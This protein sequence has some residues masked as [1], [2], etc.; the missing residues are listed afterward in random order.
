VTTNLNW[1]EAA[2]H[3]HSLHDDAHL[4]II[5]DGEEQMAIAGQLATLSVY[6]QYTVM[7]FVVFAV[8][9]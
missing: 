3:C 8:R 7:F 5:E 9:I 6:R 2:S 4:V 1:T